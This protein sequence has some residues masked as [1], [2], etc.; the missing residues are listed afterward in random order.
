[1]STGLIV[2]LSVLGI[3]GCCVC[4]SLFGGQIFGDEYTRI[5]RQQRRQQQ[6]R[7]AQLGAGLA[8]VFSSV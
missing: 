1:M 3:V 8:R 5:E 2:G 7:Q 4:F 6:V